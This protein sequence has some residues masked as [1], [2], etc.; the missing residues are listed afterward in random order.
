MNQRKD[1]YRAA[2]GRSQEHQGPRT[3]K[4]TTVSSRYFRITIEVDPDVR[5]MLGRWV[6]PPVALVATTGVAAFRLL[7]ELVPK[8]APPD[9]DRPR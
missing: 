7:T 1:N 4:V 8:T 3:P 5:R 2:L 9:A 6:M